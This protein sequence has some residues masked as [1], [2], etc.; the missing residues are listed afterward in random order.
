[1]CPEIGA[2]RRI[3]EFYFFD[4]GVFRAIRPRGPLDVAAEIDGAALETLF[5]QELR[6]HN[7]YK[8]LGYTIHYWA[9]RT[10]LEVD[11]VLYGERGLKAFEVKRGARVR[12]G[13]LRSLQA[14][15]AQYPAGQAWFLYGGTRTYNEG[16]IRVMPYETCLRA[17]PQLL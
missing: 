3:L 6:A 15:L 1:M 12:A 16:R 2:G 10:G 9:T 14:F 17:L 5:F 8:D 11:F 7:D 13:D 4:V